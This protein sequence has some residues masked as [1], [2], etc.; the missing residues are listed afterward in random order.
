MGGEI[1]FAPEYAGN[2]LVTFFDDDLAAMVRDRFQTTGS[3]LAAAYRF[4]PRW[5]LGTTVRAASGFPRTAPLGV[6]VRGVEDTLDRDLDG[7]T[8]GHSPGCRTADACAEALWAGLP[9]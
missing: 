6:V 8:D 4:T 5:E 2:P 7:I 9:R 1:A 3:Q